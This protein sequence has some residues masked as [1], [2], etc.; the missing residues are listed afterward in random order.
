MVKHQSKKEWNLELFH[1]RYCRH[2]TGNAIIV[3]TPFYLGAN[4]IAFLIF[5]FTR[6]LCEKTPLKYMAETMKLRK[7]L[8]SSMNEHLSRNYTIL[9]IWQASHLQ[10]LTDELQG[11]HQTFRI[12]DSSFNCTKF[13]KK[14]LIIPWV[15]QNHW[16][17]TLYSKYNP[18]H[19]SLEE[20]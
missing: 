3:L 16:T 4:N 20:Y 11:P 9:K 5:Y 8:K 14:N 13:H 1:L 19:F 18:L 15:I 2:K 10:N 12:P 7:S 17:H 6:Y